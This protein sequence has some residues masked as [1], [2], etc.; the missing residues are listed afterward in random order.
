MTELPG[1]EQSDDTYTI[2]AIQYWSVT[3]GLTEIHYRYHD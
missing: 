1:G 2:V 3:D